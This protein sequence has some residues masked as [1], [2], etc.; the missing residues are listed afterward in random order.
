MSFTEVRNLSCRTALNFR[1]SSGEAMSSITLS[2]IWRSAQLP[3]KVNRK[4]ELRWVLLSPR[5]GGIL[6][7]VSDYIV[8]D[9]RIKRRVVSVILTPALSPFP[10]YG[11]SYIF[12]KRQFAAVDGV[13]YLAPRVSIAGRPRRRRDVSSGTAKAQRGKTRGYDSEG[14]VAC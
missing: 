12:G 14:V 10:R 7:K 13:R 11:D 4:M 6:I 3:K 9:P 1:R 5:D 2:Y 8:I